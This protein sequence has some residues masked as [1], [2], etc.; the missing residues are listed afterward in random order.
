MTST[1]TTEQGIAKKFKNTE[2]YGVVHIETN[3]QANSPNKNNPDFVVVDDPMVT[4]FSSTEIRKA[5]D[6]GR[7]IGQ[8]VGP[9]VEAYMVALWGD[10]Q[11]R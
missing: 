10:K 2:R 8:W 11:R 7:A 3:A 6:Q 4:D 1:K 5:L 9:L